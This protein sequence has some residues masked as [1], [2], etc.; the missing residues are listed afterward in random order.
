MYKAHS[1][2]LKIGANWLQ[3]GS[4]NKYQSKLTIFTL[5]LLYSCFSI[6]CIIPW[7]PRFVY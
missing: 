5:D 7:E 3:T 2:Q 1:H 6:I 4:Q